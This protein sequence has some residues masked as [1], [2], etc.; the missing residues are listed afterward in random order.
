MRGHIRQTG[1]GS[2]EL[3]FD[4]GRDPI[5]NKRRIA[6]H[7]FKGT[8]R[9]AQ[10]ELAELV[11]AVSRDSYVEPSKTAV[12]DFVQARIDQWEAAPEG[13]TARTAQRY[14]QLIQH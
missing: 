6:Y 10:V 3:K 5:T 7:S 11:A 13:I 14:R 1:K 4:K 9:E 2:F 12:A 8:K